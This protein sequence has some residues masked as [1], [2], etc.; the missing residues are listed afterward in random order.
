MHINAT[1]ICS[2]HLQQ[3]PRRTINRTHSS[4]AAEARWFVDTSCSYRH[5]AY[6]TQ[7]RDIVTTSASPP[8]APFP[9]IHSPPPTLCEKE[10]LTQP[11][12]PYFL[13]GLHQRRGKGVPFL[14]HPSSLSRR[15]VQLC[16]QVSLFPHH[17][18]IVAG[19]VCQRICMA[20]PDPKGGNILASFRSIHYRQRGEV[21]RAP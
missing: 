4:E 16:S 15:L 13:F 19:C 3:A 5:G 14:H 10:R 1:S 20:C 12:I 21:E 2:R 11:P 18:V 17:G 8:H 9:G 6:H 7:V